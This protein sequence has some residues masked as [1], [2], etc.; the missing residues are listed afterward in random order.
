VKTEA[1]AQKAPPNPRV[2]ITKAVVY[3]ILNESPRPRTDAEVL[4]RAFTIFES[5][6]ESIV[7]TFNERVTR[8]VLLQPL[9]AAIATKKAE[10]VLEVLLTPDGFDVLA[11]LHK[12]R[13]AAKPIEEPVAQPSTTNTPTAENTQP[14]T[15]G[16]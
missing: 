16:E 13:A 4:D 2:T 7:E 8:E 5:L 9:E 14:V 15:T 11:R 1:Q 12:L 10:A 3:M 6:N